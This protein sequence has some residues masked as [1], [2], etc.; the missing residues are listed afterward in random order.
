MKLFY[1]VNY[2]QLQVFSKTNGGSGGWISSDDVPIS[3]V[4]YSISKKLTYTFFG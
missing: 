2:F 3:A 4:D 1:E